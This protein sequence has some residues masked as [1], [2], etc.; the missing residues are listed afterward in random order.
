MN[1]AGFKDRREPT[2]GYLHLAMNTLALPGGVAVAASVDQGLPIAW[3][4]G[5][6]NRERQNYINQHNQAQEDFLF[7]RN[8]QTCMKNF[9]IKCIPEV[10]FKSLKHD[11]A[12]Y[13]N[14]TLRQFLAIMDNDFP[15]TPEEKQ[16]MVDA[17]AED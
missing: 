5:V 14:V 7:D 12:G 2:Y 4:A 8:A 6:T 13:R 15:A 17:L 10:H 1:L 3:A 16:A 9:I 11:F